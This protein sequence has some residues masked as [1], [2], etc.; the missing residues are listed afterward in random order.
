MSPACTAIVFSH[1]A[2]REQHEG[3]NQTDKKT[4]KQK[5]KKSG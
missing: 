5:N 2:W 1:G 4:K 3:N